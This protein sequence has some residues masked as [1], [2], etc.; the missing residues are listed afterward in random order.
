M[1]K[2]LKASSIDTRREKMLALSVSVMV[3]SLLQ[4]SSLSTPEVEMSTILSGI[5]LSIL[6][7]HHPL[8][9][10]GRVWTHN[11]LLM[12]ATSSCS[13]S[14][15]SFVI[16]GEECRLVSFSRSKTACQ[17][18]CTSMYVCIFGNADQFDPRISISFDVLLSECY[19][20]IMTRTVIST[21]C[22]KCLFTS[23]SFFECLSW[24]CHFLL[25]SYFSKG[26]VI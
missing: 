1:A 22:K 18:L 21:H 15:P 5:L 14:R 26:E 24:D 4:Q 9:T 13:S 6:P 16:Q 3:A 19:S 2:G 20:R 8:I 12:P 25:F 10:N 7:P 11:I 23:I 17:N